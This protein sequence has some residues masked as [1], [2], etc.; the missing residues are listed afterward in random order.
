MILIL[1]AQYYFTDLST[2]SE[3]PYLL[4]IDVSHNNIAELL[5]FKAPKN[6]QIVNMS[7]NNIEE[8]TDLSEHHF[9]SG[10]TLDNILFGIWCC[11]LFLPFLVVSSY[12][13]W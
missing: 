1:N 12:F 3:M 7:Y 8:M 13:S 5:N 10:L 9:L 2:F 4:E 11:Y 6:L